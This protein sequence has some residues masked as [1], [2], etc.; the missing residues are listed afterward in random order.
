MSAKKLDFLV[1]R[2][3]DELSEVAAKAQMRAPNGGVR[4][5]ANKATLAAVSAVVSA[6]SDSY[7]EFEP[8]RFIDRLSEATTKKLERYANV[9]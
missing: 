7:I 8:Q 1:E 9:Q 4:N 5:V 2:L 6:M 3:V